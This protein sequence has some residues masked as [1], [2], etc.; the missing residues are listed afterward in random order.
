MKYLRLISF[1]F[2]LIP[3]VSCNA[4]LQQTTLSNTSSKT[5]ER[6]TLPPILSEV[7]D[8]MGKSI[9][10]YHLPYQL[11]K[12]AKRF[13]MPK[14]LKEISG[15]SISASNKE[16][17]TAIQDE[18]G[19]LFYINKNTGEVQDERPFYKPGDYEGLEV[20][21]D[22][23]YVVKSTGT[24]YEISDLEN[25]PPYVKKHKSFLTKANDVEGLCYDS[26]AHRLLLACKGTPILEKGKET[27]KFEKAIYSF[28]LREDSMETKPS[29]L[30]R[31]G[32]IQN[33]LK[34]REAM[35]QYD[36]LYSY[37]NPDVENLIF[38]P[39]AIAIHPLTGNFYMTSSPK[40]IMMVFDP[41][42]NILHLEKMDKTIH[43]QPEGLAF[44]EDGTLY[45]ANE[46]K[47]DGNGTL[48]K[49]SYQPEIA[50]H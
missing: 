31:L 27:S 43:P 13:V 32:D 42:G 9:I 33:Y 10:H 28:D 16:L 49:F 35:A 48:L 34:G 39:S 20:V 26:K 47:K 38:C 8:T 12:P 41:K 18:D 14:Q 19:I 45:I 21:G 40:K 46:G 3:F 17:I 30:F 24:I 2:C 22:T 5:I 4:R 36:K 11:S 37:F 50:R 15:L 6:D 7:L 25:A 44:D 29:F 23:V 1:V